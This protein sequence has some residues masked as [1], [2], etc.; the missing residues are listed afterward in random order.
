M[1]RPRSHKAGKAESLFG[2]IL[3]P[4]FDS[5]GHEPP[6]LQRTDAAESPLIADAI[7][8]NWRGCN[9]PKAV[10]SGQSKFLQVLS[11]EHWARE[12]LLHLVHPT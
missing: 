12:M 6:R 4:F 7:A 1:I 8:D 3:K 2:D 11:N 9:G 5:I 10:N